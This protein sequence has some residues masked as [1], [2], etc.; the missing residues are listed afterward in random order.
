MDYYIKLSSAPFKMIIKFDFDFKLLKTDL[1]KKIFQSFIEKCAEE[2]SVCQLRL[3]YLKKNVD[4]ILM[5]F[6][7]CQ[8]LVS[9]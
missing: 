1:K 8:N 5:K 9:Y 6:K 3:N 2:F 4:N 7:I